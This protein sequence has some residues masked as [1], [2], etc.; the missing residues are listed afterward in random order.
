NDGTLRAVDATT[1]N[2][3]WAFIAPEHFGKLARLEANSPKV[4]YPHQT[5]AE[6]NPLAPKDYFFDGSIGQIVRYDDDNRLS[7]AWIYPTMRRG[8]RMVYAFD[9]TDPDEPSLMWYQGCPNP[10]DDTG[11]TS[12]VSGLG[13]TWSIP[14]A[15][16]LRDASDA[17][18][19][20][21]VMGG[22]YDACEDAESASPSCGSSKGR[23]VYVLDAANGNIIKT[24]A[25]DRAVAGDVSLVDL[26]YDGRIDF[27]YAADTGGNLYRIDLRDGSPEAW[28][29]QKIARTQGGG[30]KF[31]YGPAVMP[32]RPDTVD[33]V[34]LAL[35][36]GNREQPLETDYP[37]ASDIEDRFYVFL[38]KPGEEASVANGY[39]FDLDS[40]STM[41]DYT[42]DMTCA[43]SG[44][45]PSSTQ[46]GWFMA[47]PN[48]GE[49][50]VTHALIV[51]GMATFST[52][53]PGGSSVDICSRPIGIA[54]GYWVNLFNGSGAIGDIDQICGGRR[55][56]TLAGG[57]MPPSPVIAIVPVDGKPR[58]VVI[59]A[60]PRDG[61]TGT[62]ISPQ[63]IKPV[64]NH[65]TDRLYWS[66]DVDR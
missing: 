55:S 4:A 34:Y 3:R 25:T 15:G 27:A 32:Y 14:N 6:D 23:G 53:R 13:Q 42:I 65:P 35:G 19:K 40:T 20:V 24:F 18:A 57:G 7:L 31:L 22:G 26:D 21:V 43:H 52:S 38:D 36:S 62:P 10:G 54:A 61:S 30:R 47:L 28:T 16:Y 58:T 33:F 45:T 1:G 64:G 39:P 48:R 63:E 11:C 41:F 59:G 5:A 9:V 44:V 50:T 12:G 60:P 2:E 49:Q 56:T 46:R 51:A 66:S 29:I 8:G 37:Y 17:D